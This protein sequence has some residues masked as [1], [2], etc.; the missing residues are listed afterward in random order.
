MKINLAEN[1]IRFGV[2]NLNESSISKVKTLAEQEPATTTQQP[3]ATPAEAGPSAPP[4]VKPVPGTGFQYIVGGGSSDQAKY[5][6]LIRI[7]APRPKA[8]QGQPEGQPMHEIDIIK[9]DGNITKSVQFRSNGVAHHGE[10]KDSN[11]TFSEGGLTNPVDF[12][13]SVKAVEDIYLTFGGQLGLGNIVKALVWIDQNYSAKFKSG[14]S[15]IKYLSEAKDA[16]TFAAK[17][18][19]GKTKG[20]TFWKSSED[21]LNSLKYAGLIKS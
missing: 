17:W 10:T 12:I 21:W 3:T 14:S 16:N 5:K 13:S 1:M 19:E 11:T 20:V 18:R 9:F 6:P 4:A 7:N 15:I 2:K 8:V